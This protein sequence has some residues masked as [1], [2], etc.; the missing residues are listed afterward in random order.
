M[1]EIFVR[2]ARATDE[3]VWRELWAQYVA[4]YEASVAEPITASTWTRILERR[5]GFVGRVAEAN[6]TVVGISVSVVHAC[7]WELSPICYLEDLF[8]SPAARG[9]GAGRALIE[10]L[11]ALAKDRGWARLY[12][13]TRG[14]NVVARKLYDQFVAADDFVKYAMKVEADT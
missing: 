14:S 10:D 5:D 9:T 7:S 1:S 6:G 3:A 4:F 12:W 13:H 11:L 2:D 8:V